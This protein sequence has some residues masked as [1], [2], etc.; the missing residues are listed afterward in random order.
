MSKG[1]E[2]PH[3]NTPIP[4]WLARVW[5]AIALA[6]DWRSTAL[7]A[8]WRPTDTLVPFLAPGAW[9]ALSTSPAALAASEELTSEG[10][11]SRSSPAEATASGSQPKRF[12]LQQISDLDPGALKMLLLALAFVGLSYIAVRYQG[13]GGESPRRHG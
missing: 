11:A 10:R 12:P 7:T 3:F 1:T 2:P 5:P 8:I 9:L 4:R 13:G 6:G